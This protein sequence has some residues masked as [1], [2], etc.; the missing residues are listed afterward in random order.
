VVFVVGVAVLAAV[1]GVGVGEGGGIIA[2]V[3][4]RPQRAQ[5]DD[6][7]VAGGVEA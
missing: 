2:H 1:G 3:A 7:E 5:V 6:G 4:G